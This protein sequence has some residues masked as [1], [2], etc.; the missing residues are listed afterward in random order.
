MAPRNCAMVRYD[1]DETHA[2]ARP[3][4]LSAGLEPVELPQHLLRY[5]DGG[6]FV[7]PGDVS[8]TAHGVVQ[9]VYEPV[10]IEGH[11]DGSSRH[12]QGDWTGARHRAG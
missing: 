9:V 3:L 8:D 2:A 1:Q 6:V 11:E 12:S 4:V 5:E 7:P 10:G